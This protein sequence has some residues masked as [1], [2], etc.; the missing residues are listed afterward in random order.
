AQAT[1]T[2]ALYPLSL[3]DALPIFTAFSDGLTPASKL[4]NGAAARPRL[5]AGL[6]GRRQAVVGA[7]EVEERFAVLLPDGLDLAEVEGMVARSEEHTSE[8]Q[9]REKLVSR[10]LP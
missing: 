4:P 1:P 3:H 9:S 2:S 6:D 5:L 7:T 10:R 8:L